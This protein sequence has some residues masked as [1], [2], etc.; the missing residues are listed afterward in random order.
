M[1]STTTPPP[2]PPA[3]GSGVRVVMTKWGDRPHWEFDGVFL[4][5]DEHGDWVGVPAGTRHAR[6]GM[7]FDS[8]VDTVTLAPISAWCAA[9]FHRPGIWCDT[10][11]DV[12]TPPRWHGSVLRATDL[13]LDVIRMAD[14]RPADLPPALAGWEPG[15]VLI[16]DEDEFAEHRETF[17]YPPE[18]VAAA[19][20][21]ADRLH[22][23][24]SAG[25]APY[26]DATATRWLDRLT[27]LA[28]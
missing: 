22:A 9:T 12:C 16:D 28:N 24:V 4:G 1:T 18:V 13:D 27:A 14:P 25:E 7:S 10:Y 21:S 15:A 19:R 23:A 11:I 17:G 20:A 2:G 5:A 3:P 26:D 6:P 8:D